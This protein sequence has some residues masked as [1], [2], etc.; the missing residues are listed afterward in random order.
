MTMKWNR[1]RRVLWLAGSALLIAS[2]AAAN[3][4]TDCVISGGTNGPMQ[5][6]CSLP[7][8]IA[9]GG[10]TIP[11]TSKF[12]YLPSTDRNPVT[13]A[14]GSLA[15]NSTG[16]WLSIDTTV[17]DA[18][19]P[20]NRQEVIVTANPAG[21]PPGVY[22]GSVAIVLTIGGAAPEC[23]SSPGGL[24]GIVSVRL[25]V[26]PAAPAPALSGAGLA[27]IALSLG[28]IGILALAS[29]TRRA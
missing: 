2:A 16:G 4:D 15:A 23:P 8:F 17:L 3:H 24:T 18:K 10:A 13:C 22:D 27:I 25:R 26:T 11:L 14:V 1:L 5:L 12:V 20:P 6:D 19:D 7:D 21:L 28:G 29:R 9:A